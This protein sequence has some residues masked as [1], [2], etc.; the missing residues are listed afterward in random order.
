MLNVLSVDVE[1]YFHPTE[2]QPFVD[3]SRWAEYPSRIEA[4]VERVLELFERRGAKATF[5]VLGWVAEHH[6]SVLRAIRSAGHEI[7]CHSYAHQ[8]VYR[9]NPTDFRRDTERAVAAIEDACGVAPAAYRAPSY[10]ITR[11]SLWALGVLAAGGFT[12]DSSIYPIAH[13]HYGIPGFDRHAHVILT[14]SG[15]IEEIPI[16]TAKVW[17][18]MVTPTGGG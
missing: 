4:Q 15:A 1:E 10:S 18:G 6:G 7:A 5:F 3:S 16:A 12:R 14:P 8:L 2:V 17:P 11:D 13:D 9:L